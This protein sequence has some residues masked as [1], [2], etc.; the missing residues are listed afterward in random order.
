MYVSNMAISEATTP[1]GR[2]RA[3]M[4]C[5]H[6][7]MMYAGPNVNPAQMHECLYGVPVGEVAVRP[8]MTYFAEQ[9]GRVMLTM[10]LNVVDCYE[11]LETAH[12]FR[13]D[14]PW[15]DTLGV[16]P[17]A[18][19]ELTRI[20]VDPILQP[21]ACDTWKRHILRQTYDALAH[22]AVRSG[23]RRFVAIMP[24]HVIAFFNGAGIT[25]TLLPD[26]HLA[27]ER[28]ECAAICA[29]ASRYWSPQDQRWAPHTYLVG[30][31][32]R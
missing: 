15:V 29:Q 27:I 20:A 11:R 32:L 7:Y 12:L 28:P 10:S 4:L 23:I 6:G 5:A 30:P 9:A 19:G 16:P 1:Q 8:T 24:R 14:R 3:Q 31:P 21:K 18:V 25:T 13:P 17:E 2:L 26:V 22:A